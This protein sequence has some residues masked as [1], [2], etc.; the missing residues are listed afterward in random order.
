MKRNKLILVKPQAASLTVAIQWLK[1]VGILMIIMHHFSRSLWFSAGMDAPHMTQWQFTGDWAPHTERAP[2]QHYF[3][4]P[5]EWFAR[6]GFVGV[7]MFIAASAIGHALVPSSQ[8]GEWSKFMLEKIR[9]IWLPSAISV[10]LF[11]IVTS[12]TDWWLVLAKLSWLSY[13]SPKQ[14]FAIN[15]PLWFLVLIFQ[16]YAALPFLRRINLG[17]WQLW[18][19]SLGLAY[20][21]RS[22]LSIPDLAFN[23]PYLAHACLLTWLPALI[24]GMHLVRESATINSLKPRAAPLSH[25][26]WIAL[27]LIYLLGQYSSL[28]YP[29]ADSALA[30]TFI[31]LALRLHTTF[32]PHWITT[33]SAASFYLFLYHRPLL[34]WA[35]LRCYRYF[36]DP[37]GNWAWLSLLSLVASLALVTVILKWFERQ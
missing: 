9:K 31:V 10:I 25:I 3:A 35:L 6:W 23:H 36:G 18:L 4:W 8:S 7:H 24:I 14:F 20:L 2:F 16:Y 11:S 29:L 1:A 30:L 15:S 22:L 5:F 21:T 12:N 26:K 27:A 37:L 19:V 13:L 17:A 32:I 28:L 34:S 33:L